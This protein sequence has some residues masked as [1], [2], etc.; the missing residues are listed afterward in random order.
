MVSNDL[1]D[2]IEKQ[3]MLFYP[4]KYLP[5]FVL[6]TRDIY[7]NRH[8]LKF[9]K[10]NAKALNYLL[11]LILEDHTK[12]KRFRKLDCLKV[13]RSIIRN[14]DSKKSMKRAIISKLFDVYKEFIFDKNEELKWCVSTFIKDQ[15]LEKTALKWLLANYKKSNYIVN[16]L[17]RYP[18]KN[19]LIKDWARSV[20][21]NK[22]L[23]NRTSEVIALLIEQDIPSFV[24]ESNPQIL[25]WAIYYARIN[26]K[27]KQELLKKYGFKSVRTTI[28]VCTRLGYPAVIEFLLQRLRGYWVGAKRYHK[29]HRMG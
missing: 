14:R 20:Y 17:L 3:L 5:K 13:I 6:S 4:D 7:N 16:R 21:L 18:C 28:D 29:K 26:R 23:R 19:K 10:Y 15:V 11:D 12:R 22:E 1:K 9:I 25:I 8:I 27:R 2:Y 24:K